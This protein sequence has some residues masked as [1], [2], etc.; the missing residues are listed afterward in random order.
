MAFFFSQCLHF[1]GEKKKHNLSMKKQTSGEQTSREATR[2]RACAPIG[3][4][5]FASRG[6]A[7]R[8]PNKSAH[9]AGDMAGGWS[10]W[11]TVGRGEGEGSRGIPTNRQQR[12]SCWGQVANTAVHDLVRYGR[13]CGAEMF[14]GRSLS[15][16]LVDV[17]KRA[18]RRHV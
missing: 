8:T 5:P 1:H 4:R 2:R 18:T 17:P 9:E 7:G 12:G 3:V 16:E 10:G 14:Q 15:R 11:S 13:R 6:G